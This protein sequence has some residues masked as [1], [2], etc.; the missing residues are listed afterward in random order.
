MAP[1]LPTP[2][3]E[4]SLSPVPEN[5]VA[6]VESKVAV[7]T[8]ANGTKRKI[9]TSDVKVT[10]KRTKKTVANSTADDVAPGTDDSPR[11]KRRANKK[12]IVEEDFDEE[13]KVEE[14]GEGG[15]KVTKKTTT[16]RKKKQVDLAPLAERTPNT[17]LRVGAH[18]STAGG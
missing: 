11:P 7:K 15:S 4:S 12:A 8:T 3:P 18:V 14:N 9:E 5:I 17:N 1:K 6:N 13:V 16:T 10:T 2:E